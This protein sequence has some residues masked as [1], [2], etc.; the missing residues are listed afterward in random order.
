MQSATIE[1]APPDEPFAV[2]Q[3]TG[4][5]D[6]H[7]LDGFEAE[8]AQRLK[9]GSLVIDLS[10]LEFLAVCSLR[11]LLSCERSA[12]EEQRRVV[13]AGAPQQARR[14]LHVSGLDEV[15]RVSTD[16]TDAGELVARG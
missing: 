8:V 6:L 7:T 5:L 13:Y 1:S 3:V 14:L 4:E 16:L 9:G 15:L 2:M 11:S 12:L 10:G